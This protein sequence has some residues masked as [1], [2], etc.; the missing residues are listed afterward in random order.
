LR[1]KNQWTVGIG[2]GRSG[3]RDRVRRGE[4]KGNML[5]TIFSSHRRFPRE[6]TQHAMRPTTE[7]KNQIKR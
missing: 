6:N 3:T 4:E 5:A 2:G 7:S 1:G